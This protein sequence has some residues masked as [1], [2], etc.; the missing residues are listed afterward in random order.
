MLKKIVEKLFGHYTIQKI[1]E[2]KV[3]SL[4]YLEGIGSGVTP[5]SSGE[6]NVLNLVKSLSKPYCI[7]DV[8]ANKGQYT[9]MVYN[10]FYNLAFEIHSFEPSKFTFEI[11]KESVPKD[12][13]IK[14]NNCGLSRNISEETLYY[15]EKSSGLAS[16]T[17]RR[18][19][20][21]N[22]RFDK[23]EKIRLT[24]VD[25]YCSENGIKHIHLLKIDVEGHELD[26]LNGASQMLTNTAIDIITF[27][28][29]GCNID[30]RSFF[31][32][33]FYFFKEYNMK[34]YRITP[35]GYFFPIEEYKEHYEQFRT[36]NFVVTKAV[37]A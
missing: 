4:L 15:N 6:K 33:Y 35:S 14:L 1:L 32:D 24:T 25:H 34:I 10:E 3:Q 30:T 21:L 23:T 5:S 36:T 27:E 13:K 26:V 2:K 22:I 17:K 11:L 19:D 28:F 31:Q 12:D 18:L 8:G 20:H 7:L 9:N 29:G 37:K 16:L